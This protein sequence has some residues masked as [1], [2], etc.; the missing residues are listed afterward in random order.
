MTAFAAF[1]SN[2]PLS[3]LMACGHVGVPNGSFRMIGDT[4]SHDGKGLVARALRIRPV[5]GD[6]PEI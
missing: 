2:S 3:P 4:F 5:G 6:R 1:D